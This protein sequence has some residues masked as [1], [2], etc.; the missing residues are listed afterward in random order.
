MRSSY[1]RARTLHPIDIAPTRQLVPA[2]VANPV[3]GEP[4]AENHWYQL[5]MLPYPSANGMHMGHVLNY[6]M[7]DVVTHMRRRSGWNSSRRP[8]W[9]D[10]QATVDAPNPDPT[11]TTS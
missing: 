1:T 11:T 7:G 10:R 3:P 6:T 2:N 4:T 5:E 8:A 9:A